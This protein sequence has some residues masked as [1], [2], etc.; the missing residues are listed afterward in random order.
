[1]DTESPTSKFLYAIIKQLD[2]KIVR[3]M[4]PILP[5]PETDFHSIPGRLEHCCARPRDIERPCSAHAI[6]AI[7]EPNRPLDFASKRQE[8]EFQEGREGNY[9]GRHVDVISTSEAL[10]DKHRMRAQARADGVPMPH[11]PVRQM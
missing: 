10:S 9:Q 2:L 4:I 7:Q 3:V 1:M 5:G 11:Q 6:L 8:E